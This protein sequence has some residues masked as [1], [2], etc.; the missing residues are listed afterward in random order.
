M[1]DAA[2]EWREEQ[3]FLNRAPKTQ[4]EVA[5]ALDCHLLPAFGLDPLNR[6][7]PELLRRYIFKK[8]NFAPGHPKATPVVGK[9]AGARKVPL[10]K[11]AVRKQIQ[12]LGRIYRWAIERG[13]ATTNPCDFVD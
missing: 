10:G 11:T 8:L 9:V 12:T 5:T 1:R 13:L 4:E 2:S 6:I 7:S 3:Q